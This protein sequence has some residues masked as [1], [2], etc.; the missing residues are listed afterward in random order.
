MD[1]SMFVFELLQVAVDGWKRVFPDI[2]EARDKGIFDILKP[3]VSLEDEKTSPRWKTAPVP[4]C[5]HDSTT[6]SW[7]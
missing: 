6:I 4:H 2:F 7:L 1:P 5:H 3:V